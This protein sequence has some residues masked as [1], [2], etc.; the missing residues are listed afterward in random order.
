M[1]KVVDLA[2]MLAYPGGLH[3]QLRAAKIALYRD[4]LLPGCPPDFPEPLDLGEGAGPHQQVNTPAP[5]Q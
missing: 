4:H 2:H 1:K 5:I 3:S